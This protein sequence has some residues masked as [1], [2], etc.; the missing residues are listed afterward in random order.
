MQALPIV[1]R[2]LLVAA[3][4]RMT[5][6]SR[7]LSAGILLPIFA[8]LENLHSGGRMFGGSQ[9]LSILSTIVFV[10]CM[11]AGLRYTSDCISEE[12]REGTLGLLFLTNLKG[13]DVV[14]GKVFGRGLRAIFNLLAAFPILALPILIGGVTGKQVA[15][16]C[17]TLL[18]CIVFSLSAGVFISSRGHRE[19]NVLVGTLFFLLLIS[20]V[21]IV[22]NSIAVRIFNY[23]GF[24]DT[25]PLLSPYHA[26]TEAGRGFS[27]TLPSSLWTIFL[28]SLGF[29]FYATWRVRR[30]FAEI[31]PP[32]ASKPKTN[33]PAHARSIPLHGFISGPLH[34]LAKRGRIRTSRAVAFAALSFAFGIFCWMA[35]D[36]HWNWAIPVVFFG[37]YALHLIYKFLIT[38]ETCRQLNDD[39]R[40]GSL[41]LLLA[42][43]VCTSEI[44]RAQ[45]SATWRA[46][47][48]AFI[49]LIIMNWL[50]MTHRTFD[51]DEAIAVLFPVSIIALVADT[52]LLPHRAL[53]RALQGERYTVTV[54]KTFVRTMGPPLALV[55]FMIAMFMGSNGSTIEGVVA[56]CFTAWGIFCA[57]YSVIFVKDAR[58]RL[59]KHFRTLAAGDPVPSPWLPLVPKP[60][61]LPAISPGMIAGRT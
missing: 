55:A 26:F 10:E 58:W 35:V 59:H 56:K 54:F 37:S 7:A 19:R 44:V 49:G 25:I 22:L 33:A 31:E 39:R 47:L 52:I 1:Q 40:S 41:E 23:Y 9:M 27:R 17:L 12:R 16:V 13:A 42:T 60:K 45:L 61:S 24:V 6:L 51:R 53:L 50:W 43:P 11:F 2:E 38:A 36:Q 21:P 29:L 46:W 30:T 57:V 14:L 15:A 20:F 4:Q 48:P 34:W 5:Y 8:L 28:T 18:L 32:P 3:R